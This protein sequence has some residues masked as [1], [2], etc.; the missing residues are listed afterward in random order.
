MMCFCWWAEL[1]VRSKDLFH[2]AVMESGS[3]SFWQA[4]TA[5]NA[6]NSFDKF[7]AATKCSSSPLVIDCLLV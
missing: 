2:A 3:F 5:D 6:E 4:V 7:V 1:I